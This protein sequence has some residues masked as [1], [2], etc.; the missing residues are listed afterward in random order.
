M[1]SNVNMGHQGSHRSLSQGHQQCNM[2]SSKV[3]DHQLD[4]TQLMYRTELLAAKK[5]IAD[6]KAANERLQKDLLK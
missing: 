1:H 4:H 2:H 3:F 6:M 5:R